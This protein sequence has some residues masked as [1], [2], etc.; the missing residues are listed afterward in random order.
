MKDY[1]QHFVTFFLEESA[2][3]NSNAIRELKE[4]FQSSSQCFYVDILIKFIS[5]NAQR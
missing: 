3:Q 2:T 4:I 1:Y 5:F